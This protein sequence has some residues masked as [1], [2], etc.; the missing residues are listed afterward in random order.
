M[1]E[2]GAS[3]SD[4]PAPVDLGGDPLAEVREALECVD[5]MSSDMPSSWNDEPSWYRARFYEAQSHAR[6]ALDTL[7][8]M[9]VV[10][11]RAR[12]SNCSF[13][14]LNYDEPVQDVCPMCD[15]DM[16]PMV[17]LYAFEEP[18]RE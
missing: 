1:G 14:Y 15:C 2:G 5:A 3:Q 7:R 4:I 12:C 13:G 10:A 18:E 11:W 9:R 8:R 17:P 6:A 16:E